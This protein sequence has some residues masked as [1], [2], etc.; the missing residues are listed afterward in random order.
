MEN[1]N[2]KKQDCGCGDGC[3]CFPSSQCKRWCKWVVL[4]VILIAAGVII[5]AKLVYGSGTASADCCP[6][7]S[8]CCPQPAK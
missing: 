3:C 5:A 2:E 8:S 1:Q 4:A 7:R 6:P